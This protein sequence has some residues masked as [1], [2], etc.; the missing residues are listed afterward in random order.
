MTTL[1]LVSC[2]G[3]QSLERRIIP[4]LLVAPW[5]QSPPPDAV[6]TAYRHPAASASPTFAPTFSYSA[7]FALIYADGNQTSPLH[8]VPH[9]PLPTC[10]QANCLTISVSASLSLSICVSLVQ[11][12]S[13][14]IGKLIFFIGHL[15][16]RT[17]LPH[18]FAPLFRP[19]E[20]PA[21]SINGI[22]RQTFFFF[23]LNV[24]PPMNRNK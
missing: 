13:W 21:S 1:L 10:L 5:F 18:L 7:R 15:R 11:W 9:R 16:L 22:M 8:W 6:M 19:M 23:G 17:T 3:P 24:A 12:P 4:P 20:P 2:T 14:D